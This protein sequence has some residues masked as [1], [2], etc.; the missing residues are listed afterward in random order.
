[1][2]VVVLD[3]D[4]ASVLLRRRLQEP[5]AGRLA[6]NVL[7]ATF[8]TVGELT[9]WTLVRR[10]GPQRVETMRTFID[11]LVVLPYD[12]RVAARWVSYRPMPDSAAA[13]DWE[14][15]TPSRPAR[16]R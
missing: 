6:G 3:T 10:W 2:S 14:P 1:M 7:A 5:L 11:G 13:P 12:R 4:V 16:T 8:V 9:K 15:K